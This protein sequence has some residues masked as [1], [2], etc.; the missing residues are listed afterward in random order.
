[1]PG[2][3]LAVQT[4]E[5]WRSWE[6][7]FMTTCCRWGCPGDA[8]WCLESPL[9]DSLPTRPASSSMKY[10]L[11]SLQIATF[12]DD[13]KV[14]IVTVMMSMAITLMLLIDS[15]NHHYVLAMMIKEI[16][17]GS[18]EQFWLWLWMLEK[19]LTVTT[20]SRRLEQ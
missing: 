19:V 10:V 7:Q 1:M 18:S 6:M 15:K 3:L 16:I 17:L 20:V 12:R 2:L 11:C 14:R 8:S 13:I 5:W 4:Q 9:G